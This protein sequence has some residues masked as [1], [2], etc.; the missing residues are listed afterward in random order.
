[1][2]L[3]SITAGELGSDSC[4]VQSNLTRACDIAKTWDAVI[5]IDEADIFLE[6]RTIHDLVR[7]QLVSSMDGPFRYPDKAVREAF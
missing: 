7:N 1:V 3:Y 6:K 5:L 4:S 2:P